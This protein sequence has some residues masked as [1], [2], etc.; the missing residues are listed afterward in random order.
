MKKVIRLTEGDLVRLVKKVLE[1]QSDSDTRRY[2]LLMQ[3]IKKRYPNMC[4]YI[5]AGG[6]RYKVDVK[7]GKNFSFDPEVKE[8]QALY[9]KMSAKHKLIV[10]GIIGP[11]MREMFCTPS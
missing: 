1:E 10:D 6:N 7:Q 3:N 4:S 9:N 11:Q 5:A 2:D 8:F